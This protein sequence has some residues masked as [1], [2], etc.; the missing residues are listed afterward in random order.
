MMFL[1][2]SGVSVLSYESISAARPAT[3]GQA[4]LVP[5]LLV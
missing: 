5:S 4:M 3:A 1:T 2:S